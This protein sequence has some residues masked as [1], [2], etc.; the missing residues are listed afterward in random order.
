MSLKAC[1]LDQQVIGARQQIQNSEFPL[2]V[3]DRFRL[4]A[5]H[6]CCQDDLRAGNDCAGFIYYLPAIF[7]TNRTACSPQQQLREQFRAEP[8]G[9]LDN[10]VLSHIVSCARCLDE[11]NSLL[12]LPPLSERYPTDMLGPDRKSGGGRGSGPSGGSATDAFRRKSQRRMKEVVEHRPQELLIAVNGFILG[13][14]KISAELSELSLRI[15]QAEKIGF[16]EVFSEQEMRLLFLSVEPP[17]DGVAQYQERAE[18]SDGR[19]LELSLSFS[20]N[21][22]SLYLTYHDPALKQAAILESEAEGSE[23][24]VPGSASRTDDLPSAQWDWRTTFSRR[25]FD[26]RS[27]LFRPGAAPAIVAVALIAALLLVQMRFAPPSVTAAE[28]LRRATVAEETAS[29]RADLV[30]HR[31]ISV[32]ERQVDCGSRIADCGLKSTAPFSTRKLISQRRVEVWQSAAQGLTARRVYDERNQLVAGEWT[33]ADGARTIYKQEQQGQRQD[34]DSIRNPQSTIR[35]PEVWQ[36]EPSAKDF[37]ALIGRADTAR[38]EETPA[39][40]VIGYEGDGAASTA[41][42]ASLIRARLVLSKADLH[43]IEQVLLVRVEDPT[44]QLR[45]YRYLE[46]SFERRPASA[47]PLAVFEPEPE[48]LISA[49]DDVEKARRGDAVNLPPPPHLPIS[50]SPAAATTGL[51]VELLQYLHQAGADLGEQVSVT[52]TTA[53]G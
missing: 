23:I 4:L 34:D 40:Y 8:A 29:S 45:E 44:P 25:W 3:G 21:W 46:T 28:L 9:T 11:V 50:P 36:L 33:R 15:N 49:M 38:V 27:L 42:G 5:I 43:A 17:P 37:S 26:L 31:T 16:V 47:A 35:N 2:G 22:P 1:G 24:E 52:R 19:A 7:E 20:D 51:E 39:A 18:L 10:Q 6:Y 48:L 41:S 53:S 30:S 12:G 13:A 32:E 14:Q